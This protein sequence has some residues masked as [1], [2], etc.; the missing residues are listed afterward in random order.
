MKKF[1]TST[2]IA[3]LGLALCSTTVLAAPGELIS[4]GKVEVTEGTAGGTEENPKDPEDPEK[5]VEPKE[6]IIVNPDK[7][8]LVI[9]AVTALDFEKI[10]TG[11]S[12]INKTAKE[13]TVNQVEGEKEVNRGHFVQWTDIRSSDNF[14]YTL[15][16]ELTKQFTNESAEG[17]SNTLDG[18]S[19]TYSNGMMNSLANFEYW[20]N[21]DK[22][23]F[24]LTEEGSVNVVTADGKDKVGKGEYF[25][26]FG[27]SD[28]WNSEDHPSGNGGVAGTAK[29][30]VELTVPAATA[31]TMATGDYVAEITWTLEAAM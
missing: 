27:Q 23:T 21:L 3:T 28:D 19:I 5:E 22:P 15:K 8:S 26:E 2:L 16:A 30:S 1:M 14:G 29:D 25:V 11:V 13:V 6:P 17:A 24:E 20:G 31:S 10:E 4:D 7:G 12:K 18:S 9:Q